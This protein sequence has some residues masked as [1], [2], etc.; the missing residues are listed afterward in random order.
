MGGAFGR[1]F[2]YEGEKGTRQRLATFFSC[3]EHDAHNGDGA[4]QAKF[5]HHTYYC[6]SWSRVPVPLA[7]VTPTHTLAFSRTWFIT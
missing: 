4:T 2:V 1:L 6:Q 7:C 3:I 5:R